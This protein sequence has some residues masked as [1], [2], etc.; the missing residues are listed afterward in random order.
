MHGFTRSIHPSF[1]RY[2][3]CYSMYQQKTNIFVSIKKIICL[4]FCFNRMLILSSDV[5]LAYKQNL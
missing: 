3:F 2:S 5:L 1:D 4:N